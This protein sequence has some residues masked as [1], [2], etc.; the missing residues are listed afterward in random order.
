MILAIDVGNSCILLGCIRDGEIVTAARLSTEM[1]RTE[2]E[3]AILIREILAVRGVDVSELD[4]AILSSVVLPMNAVICRAVELL[5]GKRPLVVGK[6]VK[7]GLN[8]RI[9]DPGQVGSNLVVSAVAGMTLCSPPMIL[10]DM[11]AA[12]TMAAVD[13]DGHF[14][15]GAILPGVR[16]SMDALSSGTSQLPRVSL[17]VPKRCIGTNTVSSMQSGAIF[18]TAAMLDG[19]IDRMEEELGE[20]AAVIATGDM[21]EKVIPCCRRVIRLEPDLLLKGMAVLWEKNRR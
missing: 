20:S 21:A 12:T 9:D 13:R 11:S 19:M 1:K 4:G 18:G 14:L 5:I 16:L 3:Y 17:D 6:G 8:I 15:G 7:T 2:D 10:I